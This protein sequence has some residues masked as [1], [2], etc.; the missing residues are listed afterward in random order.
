MSARDCCAHWP[1]FWTF[2]GDVWGPCQLQTT[3]LDLVG[4]S[5]SRHQRRRT[6]ISSWLFLPAAR[7]FDFQ[8]GGLEGASCALTYRLLYRYNVAHC[9]TLIGRVRDYLEL[10]VDHRGIVPP[11]NATTVSSIPSSRAQMAMSA[12]ILLP[13]MRYRKRT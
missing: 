10:R 4:R 1:A 7:E 9:R 13:S 8:F 3:C 5:P 11:N 6:G 2:R 12:A